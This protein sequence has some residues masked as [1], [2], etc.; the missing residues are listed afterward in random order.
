MKIGIIGG[1][2][3]GRA[4]ARA[5]IEHVDEVRVFDI[6][7]ERA[8]HSGDAVLECDLIFICLPTPQKKD[9]LECDLSSIHRQFGY[10]ATS[11]HR[12]RNYVLR[13]TVP[14]GTTRRLA[15][16]YRIPN[17]VHSPEFLTARCAITDAQIPSRNIVG[18][19][20]PN[21][22]GGTFSGD[23]RAA[24]M[25]NILYHQRFPATQF[26]FM[27]SDE[28]E[29]VKLFLNGFFAVKVAYFNEINTLATKLGLSWDNVLNGILSDGRISP[30]HTRV[31]GPDGQYGFGGTCLPKDLASLVNHF[32]DAMAVIPP[33]VSH[34]AHHR[35]QI[36]RER[37]V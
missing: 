19:P 12:H 2:V 15:E 5:F 21:P 14:I 9:S 3:V 6:V 30:S 26:L 33:F 11:E 7:K 24:Q 8:T 34:G 17:L 35:N 32:D 23:N 13:S 22:T 4:T 16:Q 31:P 28:S 20:D 25:L 29:A 18:V 27:S 1:G 37:T 36:D 10:L